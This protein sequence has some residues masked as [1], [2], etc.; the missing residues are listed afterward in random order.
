MKEWFDRIRYKLARM[1][2]PQYFED[3]EERLSGLLWHATG[4]RLSK[5][6]YT[7]EAMESAVDDYFQKC[8]DECE[9]ANSKE[10]KQ[11]WI[12]VEERL[13][14]E[15]TRVIG[16]VTEKVSIP[17]SGE[18]YRVGNRFHFSTLGY[19]RPIS[20]WMPLPEPPKGDAE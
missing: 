10:R 2:Y 6:N 19:N 11:E 4:G 12:S 14:N 20:Y 3:I 7:L 1:I 15:Y 17:V 13:P 9:F 5:P 8:C 16:C 18:C